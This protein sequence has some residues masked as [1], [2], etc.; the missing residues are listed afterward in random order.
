MKK[1]E[2]RPGQFSSMHVILKIF[3]DLEA[4]ETIHPELDHDAVVLHMSDR[5]DELVFEGICSALQTM[6]DEI[7]ALPSDIV[8]AVDAYADEF[9]ISLYPQSNIQDTSRAQNLIWCE[10]LLDKGT[11]GQLK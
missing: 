1:I 4:I 11:I 6:K 8:V 5:F 9:D 2:R 10:N 3:P 7:S